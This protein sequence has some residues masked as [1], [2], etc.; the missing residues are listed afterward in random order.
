M[1]TSLPTKICGKCKEYRLLIEF[2]KNKHGVDGLFC[3][4]NYCQREYYLNYNKP[5]KCEW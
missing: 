5:I 2:C 3:I 1:E 4:F